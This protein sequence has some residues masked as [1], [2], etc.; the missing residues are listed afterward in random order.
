MGRNASGGGVRFISRA[1]SVG[2][3][4]GAEALVRLGSRE[5]LD[6]E[7]AAGL[8]L[9]ENDAA[10][11][12]F[13]RESLGDYVENVTLARDEGSYERTVVRGQWRHEVV[14]GT[15]VDVGLH[16]SQMDGESIRYKQIGRGTAGS[17]GRSDCPFLVVGA[18]PGN[19]CVDQ[20]GFADSAAFDE[21]YSG[22]PDS[23]S[24]TAAGASLRIERELPGVRLTSLTAYEGGDSRR[25]EDADGGPSYLFAS[26][27]ETDSNQW[28][29]DIQLTSIGEGG[30]G[31]QFGIFLLGE[32]ASYTSVRRNANLVLTPVLIP[33]TPIPEAGVRTTVLYRDLEQ[34]T[35]HASAWLRADRALTDATTLTGEIR[36]A[37][38]ELSGDLRQGVWADTT[39]DL[40]PDQFLGRKDVLN[41]AATSVAVG[42]GALTQLCPAPFALTRC[43]TLSPFERNDT[44]WGGRLALD[45]RF[46]REVLGYVSL[47]RGFKGAGVSPIGRDALVGRAGRTVDPERV[48]TFELGAKSEWRDRTLRI[49]GS[50]F[51]NDWSDYQLYLSVSTPPTVVAA[52]LE[53]L[54]KARTWGGELEVEWAPSSTW[55]L[56]GGLGLT[57]SEV[58]DTGDIADATVGSPL[59]AV[60]QLTFEALAAHTWN[61]AGGRLTA[62]LQTAYNDERAFSLTA[63][64]HS[65][66]P[67]TRSSTRAHAISSGRTNG[68]R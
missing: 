58:R 6:I 50:A 63:T 20:T 24:A 22:N 48:L 61:L 17:P 8:P 31:W 64:R 51:M 28:S 67:D 47:A 7:L 46:T 43:Y 49:N 25:S 52:V 65:S 3:E 26:W 30:S 12:A 57:Y 35:R 15:R 27:Q 10:R 33:G 36:I 14:G 56:H 37:H 23:F 18:D 21:N 59:I 19:G 66:S 60:P 34:R 45:H 68:T 40:A 2:D 29:Q 44:L 38:E 32:D 53:N 42:P 5:R 9:G 55:R 54:P 1:P 13:S 62:Q 41:F 4:A 16:G 39:P 11:L